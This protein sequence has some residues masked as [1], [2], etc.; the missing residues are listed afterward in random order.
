MRFDLQNILYFWKR[1]RIFFRNGFCLIGSVCVCFLFVC[2]VNLFIA[3][4]LGFKRIILFS[5]WKCIL[6]CFEIWPYHLVLNCTRFSVSVLHLP[7]WLVFLLIIVALFW[8]RKHL[9][10][11]NETFRLSFVSTISLFLFQKWHDREYAGWLS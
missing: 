10:S 6:G 11:I 8:Y 3:F 7:S 5:W 2:N 9:A 1:I 4:L